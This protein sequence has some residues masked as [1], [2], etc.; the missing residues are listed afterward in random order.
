[1]IA[2]ALF[3][4][5]FTSP[6]ETYVGWAVRPSVGN[7]PFAQLDNSGAVSD[8]VPGLLGLAAVGPLAFYVGLA[9]AAVTLGVLSV[10]VL[11]FVIANR[12]SL[13]PD[14]SDLGGDCPDV[15]LP[16]P[17]TGE[18]GAYFPAS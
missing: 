17:R 10:A 12:P 13:G 3:S 1:M 2:S 11:A 7:D 6:G 18:A 9:P 16:N 4:A 8:R 5:Q 15:T 14:A